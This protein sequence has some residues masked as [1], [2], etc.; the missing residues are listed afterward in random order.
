M[1]K[2]TRKKNIKKKSAINS[3]SFADINYLFDQYSKTQ[4]EKTLQEIM[5]MLSQIGNDLCINSDIPIE[6]KLKTFNEFLKY[7]KY[8]NNFCID[9]LSR[10]R[11]SLTF[12]RGDAKG[13]VLELL[14]IIIDNPAVPSH[15]RV[16]TAV[17]FYNLGYIHKCYD[18]FMKLS[19]DSSLEIQHR[20][21]AIKFLFVSDE[22]KYKKISLDCL[23]DIIEN[24]NTYDCK[25]RYSAII[26]YTSKKGI[27]TILN[28]QKLNIP[29]DE[30]FVLP[31]QM[32][33]FNNEKNEVRYRI[34]SAQH[35]LQ[36]N[37]I[38]EEIK[39]DIIQELFVI[40]TTAVGIE[41]EKNKD[42]NSIKNSSTENIRADAADVIYRLGTSADKIKARTLILNL[43]LSSDGRRKTIVPKTI[44]DNSQN[45]HDETI[46]LH[47]QAYIEKMV[48]LSSDVTNENLSKLISSYTFE[49][50]NNEISTFMRKNYVICNDEENSDN[51]NENKENNDNVENKEDEN[52]ENKINTIEIDKMT[53]F[54]RN[55]VYG[56]LHRINI[57]TA[58]FTEHKVTAAEILIHIWARIHS[59]EFDSTMVKMLEKRTIE[60][61]DDTDD[62]CS[63]GYVTRLVN[64]LSPVDDTI[65]ISWEAQIMANVSGRMNKRIRDCKDEDIQFGIASGMMENA[66]EDSRNI[67]LKFVKEQFVDIE[68]ELYKEFVE[69]NHI[70]SEEFTKY[71][72]NVKK[73][74]LPIDTL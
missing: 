6:Q 45:V 71:M 25:L 49:K 23:L 18:S 37:I 41:D 30:D 54:Q 11:D 48:T 64:I 35:L 65:R 50:V 62:S 66:D 29:Y 22:D 28:T 10:W 32:T 63:S 33:F 67:Y 9:I 4:N 36:M 19:A 46:D 2:N 20:L 1:S 51:I 3:Y 60:E 24:H 56:S 7:E 42:K 26:A 16:Y 14:T 38:K 21:E 57:D 12:L 27:T 52:K 73:E 43:G 70:K 72:T 47:T 34:L 44:Y 13:D 74:W 5:E 69:G 8:T 61:L 17:Y 39:V 58:N 53:M 40:A 55:A 68:I 31:L 59:G 15:D